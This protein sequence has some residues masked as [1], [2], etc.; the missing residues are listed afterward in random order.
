MIVVYKNERG[1]EMGIF[2]VAAKIKKTK[3]SVTGLTSD[4]KEKGISGV[5]KNIANDTKNN[6]SESIQQKKED[7]ELA[8]QKKEEFKVE[9]EEYKKIFRSTQKMGDIEID[10][11]NK[12]LKINNATNN[13]STNSK[14][15]SLG[16][17]VLAVST[18]G[19]SV[20]VQMALKPEDVIFRYDE[21]LNYDLL[22]NDLSVQS[23][24]LGRAI[25]GG[26]IG[27]STG[28]IVGGMT[29]KRKTRKSIDMLALQI[30]TTDFCFPSIMISYIKSETK[31]NSSKY[32]KILSEAQQTIACLNLIFSQCKEDKNNGPTISIKTIEATDPYE[33]VKK[34]KEL[35]DMGII[36]QKDFDEKKKQLLNL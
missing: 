32:T 35:L 4:I 12:L 27:G 34:A 3:E 1:K 16:K 19:A 22:E 18:L 10:D 30:M 8:Q 33:E 9:Q 25:A 28:G 21:I 5:A 26:V 29:G 11:I 6:I 20:A 24:G 7:A 31:T 13:I 17:G 14:M 15:K 2:D 23:G 36:T